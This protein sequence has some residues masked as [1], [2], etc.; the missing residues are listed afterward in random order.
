MEED[1]PLG[2]DRQGRAKARVL[3][4]PGASARI[5][6]GEDKKEHFSGHETSQ[7]GEHQDKARQDRAGKN[8]V[9]VGQCSGLVSCKARARTGCGR[10][11][12]HFKT[13]MKQCSGVDR[14]D[15]DSEP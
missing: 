5:M 3:P 7:S 12:G 11:Q 6:L 14:Q 4:S 13:E 2:Y 10:L 1:I 9:G 8:E 15:Q